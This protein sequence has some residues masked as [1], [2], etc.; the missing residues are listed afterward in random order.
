[1]LRFADVKNGRNLLHVV[2]RE[3][4]RLRT[5]GPDVLR[6]IARID[7]QSSDRSRLD[8]DFSGDR[9]AGD[10]PTMDLDAP[11]RDIDRQGSNRDLEGMLWLDDSGRTRFQVTL[12]KPA[13]RFSAVTRITD[14]VSDEKLQ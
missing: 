2:A 9:P 8:E 10:T 4:F 3:P 1:M 14:Q 5:A 12:E 11:L 6:Q 13:P 7:L